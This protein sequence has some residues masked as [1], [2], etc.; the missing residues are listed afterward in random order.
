MRLFIA[1]IL[2]FSFTC[3]LFSQNDA[4]SQLALQY[5]KDKDYEKAVEIFEQL[6]ST[7]RS[8]VYF[9]YYINCLIELNRNEDAVKEV[10]K[11]IKRNPDDLS[12]CVELGYLY[13]LSGDLTQA[14]EEYQKAIKKLIPHQTYI[15]NLANAFVG[16]REF[17]YAE[18]VY[19]QGRKMLKGEYSFN[20]ELA[21]I[22][23]YKRDFQKMID[24]Y[25]D[26]LIINE[27]YIQ[28]V[29]NSLQATIYGEDESELTMLLKT[30]LIKRIQKYPDIVI[31]SELLIWQYLQ[32][33]D[34]DNAFIHTKALDKRENGQGNRIISLGN[35]AVSNDSYDIAIN[36]Y[37]YVI[38]LGDN[39]LLYYEAKNRYLNAIYLKITSNLKF[40]LQ[41]INDL[42]FNYEQTLAEIG[43]SD[44]SINLIVELAHIKAFYLDKLPESITLLEEAIKIPKANTKQLSLC[45]L[46]LGDI[47]LFSNDPWEAT[48]YYAQVEQSNQE[49]PVGHEAKFRKAKLAYYTG[50]FKWAQ[51]Q[52]DVLKASTSK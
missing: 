18:T 13:K 14:D 50:N 41:E 24:E 1:F 27:G 46:E 22:Y 2:L 33:K 26:L 42:E 43:K 3:I 20:F 40:T 51:A 39:N 37:K 44:R 32:E 16:K 30:N 17:D 34:F 49:N 36:C 15:I 10:K 5:Y 35:M 12:F 8:K 48:L 25:L 4:D 7:S 31:Y 11:Q 29:Q 38:D 23:R 52:L 19:L 9:T 6:Y 21:S 47:L 28:S 45:K